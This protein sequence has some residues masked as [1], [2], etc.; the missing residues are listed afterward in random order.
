[1]WF[2]FI[3][4]CVCVYI[5]IYKERN[6]FENLMIIPQ[7]F[8]YLLRWRFN[9]F[10]YQPNIQ[11][12]LKSFLKKLK[13]NI[14]SKLSDLL[15]QKMKLKHLIFKEEEKIS[16]LVKGNAIQTLFPEL[17]ESND[18]FRRFVFSF[19]FIWNCSSCYYPVYEQQW[20]S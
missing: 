9:H 16:L 5:Y 8:I 2:L 15:N 19:C 7:M 12:L 13:T 1:M 11:E 6:D 10:W 18:F 3:L 4:K 14:W 17:G 20:L